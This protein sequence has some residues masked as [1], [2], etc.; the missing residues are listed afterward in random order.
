[1]ADIF[2]KINVLGLGSGLDLQGLL[3]QL[4][5]IEEQPIKRLEA[6]KDY[7]ESRL[8][9]FDW[10]N[11][12]VLSLKTK[13]LDL[14]LEST[15]LA[16]QVSVSGSGVEAEAE[17]GALEG[18]YRFNV[19]QL[20]RKSLWQSE[21]FA[22]KDT[23]LNPDS[24]DVL[25]L[26]VGEQSFSLLVP[27]GTTLEGLARLIN[28]AEDNPGIEA[29]VVDT[30]SPSNPYRLILKARETGEDHRIVVTQEL[31]G[32]DFEEIVGVPNIWRTA[33]YTSPD[34]VV[35]DS[36]GDI[37]LN[38][39][40]GE[41]EIKVVV[42]DGTTLSELKDLINDQAAGNSSLRAYLIR[43]AAGN[44]FLDLRSPETLNLTQNP[45]T[46]SLFPNQIEDTGESLNAFF[47]IDDIPYQRG[48]N[49]I[50]DIIPG[51]K[52]EL[53]GLGSGII[54]V[55]ADYE[56]VKETFSSFVEEVNGFL[57]ELR[58]KMSF[59]LE[60]GEEGPLYRSNAA[61][62]LIRDLRDIL[63]A[64]LSENEHIISLF[65][66]GLNFN[67]DGSLSLDQE[68][69]EQ[70]FSSYPEEIKQLM[71]GNEERNV[72]G[73]AERLNETL[74]KYLGTSGLIALEQD[75]TERYI[76]NIDH[77][78]ILAKERVDRYIANLQRQFMALDQYIQELND[79]SSYLDVQFKSIMGLTEKK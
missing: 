54:T 65:D 68:K 29:Q 4:R 26:E 36:G 48:S 73:L 28:E 6:K 78:I 62:N 2:G 67:R 24:D 72:E 34:D 13:A 16:R 8:T 59:D 30:G 55:S 44:Y 51:V 27:Q 35:N 31:Q 43:D 50:T 60:T 41:Q 5:E 1:M 32:M 57:D 14:S 21:G 39:S 37:T 74:Q 19:N 66:L 49:E 38:I 46:P 23:V 40:V 56:G 77:N 79:M 17:V 53:Q 61:E 33:S 15:Y 45:S 70:A 71:I 76:E 63:S 69:L 22:T 10:L 42:P 12:K 11:T 58:E 75:T 52:L 25:Q 18:S 7:Y 64:S 3:D 47:T 20:A 9:E